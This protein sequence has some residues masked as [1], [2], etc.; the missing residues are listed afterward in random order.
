MPDRERLLTRYRQL[1][2]DVLPKRAREHG[3][4]V[5]ADHCL[6]R[7]VLDHAVGGCWYDVLGRTGGPAFRR[8][9]DG[10]LAEAVEL[11]ERIDRGGNPV[12]RELNDQSLRWRAQAGGRSAAGRPST[13]SR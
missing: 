2:L 1:V 5:T 13:T 9:D 10:Q 12:L 8:L 11:A 4:V 3:W 7:I 6:G